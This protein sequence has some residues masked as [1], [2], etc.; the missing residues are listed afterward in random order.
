MYNT[1]THYIETDTRPKWIYG[2]THGPKWTGKIS[3]KT[4]TTNRQ[5]SL[6]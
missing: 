1:I 3:E 4:E 2:R 5:V 6:Q